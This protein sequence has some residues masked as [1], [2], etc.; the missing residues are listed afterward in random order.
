MS[1]YF[2]LEGDSLPSELEDSPNGVLFLENH[3][4]FPRQWLV[5]S[6]DTTYRKRMGDAISRYKAVSVFD[7]EKFADRAAEQGYKIAFLD[8]PAPIFDWY[9][10][11]NDDPGIGINS[12][13]E[14]TIRG[15]LPF[16]VQGLNFAKQQRATVAQWSTG[17]GK[18][19]LAN[20]LVAWHRQ[21]KNIDLCL[22]IVKSHNKINTHRSLK[23][24]VDLDSYVLDNRPEK[25]DSMYQDVWDDTQRGLMP[26]LVMHYETFRNDK[27]AFNMLIEDKRLL[28]VFDEMPT[29]L[30]NRTT[31]LYRAVA[32]MLYT[33]FSVYKKKKIFYPKLGSE[34]PSKFLS[35]MLSATPIENSPEDWFNCV[36]LMQPDIYGSVSKFNKKFVVEK[37]QWDRPIAWQKLDLMGSMAAHIVHQVDKEDPDI[38]EQFPEVMPPET[39]SLE[40][41]VDDLRIYNYLA[42]EYDKMRDDEVGMLKNTDI[43]GAINVLQMICS[44]PR[45]VL[46]S[47]DRYDEYMGRR[48]QFI[49]DEIPDLPTLEKW[50]K[51]N[52]K[53][54][55]IAH[56]LVKKL[57]AKKFDD[58]KGQ[59]I[60]CVKLQRL[61]EDLEEHSKKAIVF[62]HLNASLLPLLTKHLDEWGISHVLFHGDLTMKQKQEVQDSFKN[63]PSIQVFL[64]SDSGSDSINL[65][66][67]NLVIH[68]DRPLTWAKLIQR[69]NRC[70]RITSTHASVRYI[71][72]EVINSVE[73]RR[74]EIVEMK[75]GYHQATFKGQI[76]EQAMAMRKSDLIYIL[77]G[78]KLD[79]DE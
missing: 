65:E 22:F 7:F 44:N 3:S 67:A 30:K 56:K 26:I 45:S 66:E 35:L 49:E 47:S 55:E 5:S 16:Q 4:R 39:I 1:E 52:K 15:L 74:R 48:A 14:G 34:R 38:A 20:A 32:E 46:R 64:S 61:K 6:F 36:R 51:K 58:M 63:D 71:T 9:K 40:L 2:V 76:A 50:D 10:A 59:E 25:R 28:V 37:N 17:T 21:Q 19:V 29:K 54:S 18:S 11:L 78:R 68:Y 70:H 31:D 57:G 8:D 12:T 62:T 42:E 13:L 23:K 41:D 73:E 24:M 75:K 60:R 79:L 27:D 53:G 77:L 69:Q 43:L 33:S 72:Y